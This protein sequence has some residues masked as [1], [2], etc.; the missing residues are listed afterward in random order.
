MADP[1]GS[2]PSCGVDLVRARAAVTEITACPRCGGVWLDVASSQRVVAGLLSDAEKSLAQRVQ[3]QVAQQQAEAPYRATRR[4]QMRRCPECG[5]P[6]AQARLGEIGVEL[7]VCAFHGTWFDAG[8]LR[9]VEQ[10]YAL[11]SAAADSEVARFS[12]ELSE[13]NRRDAHQRSP[14]VSVVSRFLR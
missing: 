5:E 13:A 10:F 14:A 4:P 2:C 8:E 12:Q 7:D 6:L 1:H 9:P 3:H 11:E